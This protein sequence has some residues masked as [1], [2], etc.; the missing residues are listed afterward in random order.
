[1]PN[2]T[3]VIFHRASGP[4]GQRRNKKET[5]VRLVHRP[6]GVTAGASE[7]RSQTQNRELAFERLAEKLRRRAQRKKKRIPTRKSR[8]V[9]ERELAGKKK[10]AEKK[11]L[12]RPVD[13]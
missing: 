3:T 4:G 13:L 11:K 1:M 9:R 8:S 2:E 5:A 12:R 10:R 6:T 7:R